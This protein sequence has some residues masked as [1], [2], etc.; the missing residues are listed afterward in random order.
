M[1]WRNISKGQSHSFVLYVLGQNHAELNCGKKWIAN[2]KKNLLAGRPNCFSSSIFKKI[3]STIDFY[4]IRPIL[5]VTIFQLVCYSL[6]IYTLKKGICRPWVLFIQFSFL[7]LF[8]SAKKNNIVDEFYP[9][10]ETG[11]I[12]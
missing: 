7:L 2:K 6:Y 3:L 5:F 12:F 9:I 10:L 8:C 11:L 4:M 1:I